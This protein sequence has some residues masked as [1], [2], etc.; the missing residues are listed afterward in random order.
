[1][2]VSEIWIQKCKIGSVLLSSDPVSLLLVL[3]GHRHLHEF[4]IH[5]SNMFFQRRKYWMQFNQAWFMYQI[6][7]YSM[8]GQILNGWI[9][10]LQ[11][12]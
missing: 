5:T 12:V 11:G 7:L 6:E 1:M 4:D 2:T 3:A 9:V 10:R 8:S